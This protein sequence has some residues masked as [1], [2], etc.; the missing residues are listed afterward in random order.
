MFAP[1]P[2]RPDPSFSRLHLHDSIIKANTD[3][4]QFLT[5]STFG[6]MSLLN[7]LASR[8]MLGP[9]ALQEGA[10]MDGGEGMPEQGLQ[11]CQ[12]Q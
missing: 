12:T 7:F 3:P 4:A 5:G 11:Q 8:G 1:T 6:R 2:V 10:A 9:E